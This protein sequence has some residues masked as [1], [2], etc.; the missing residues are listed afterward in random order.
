M[1]DEELLALA[2]E[3]GFDC[4]APLDATK[5]EVLEDVR[6]ACKVNLCGQYNKTWAC[7][8]AFGDLEE[9]RKMLKK[10]PTSATRK[11]TA[12]QCI[13]YL[14]LTRNHLHQRTRSQVQS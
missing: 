2:A 8:P 1:T 3:Y 12:M 4:S 10:S 14:I 11:M 6:D 9:S 13:L 7:P 5:L